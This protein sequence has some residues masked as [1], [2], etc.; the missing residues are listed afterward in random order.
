M[1]SLAFDRDTASDSAHSGQNI[2]DRQFFFQK[3]VSDNDKL[4]HSDSYRSFF[5]GG[6]HWSN[7]T[8]AVTDFV[9]EKLVL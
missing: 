9:S 1:R 2:D 6:A 7:T 8:D 4:H 5:L 3:N